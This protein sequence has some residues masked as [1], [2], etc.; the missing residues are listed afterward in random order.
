MSNVSILLFANLSPARVFNLL[1]FLLEVLKC[2]KYHIN[3]YVFD[4]DY[5]TPCSM[6][7]SPE[8]KSIPSEH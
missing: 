3:I 2:N 6:E 7:H 1:E 5:S 8:L 4:I